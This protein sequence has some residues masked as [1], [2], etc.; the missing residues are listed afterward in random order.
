MII[1]PVPSN[2]SIKYSFAT[3][4]IKADYGDKVVFFDL[5]EI[6]EDFAYVPQEPIISVAR[7]DQELHVELLSSETESFTPDVS[8]FVVT[9][10]A[11]QPEII[12]QGE[13]CPPNV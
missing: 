9:Q 4:T 13:P 8:A 1:H 12:L 11:I 3:N 7:I 5:S 6:V 10:E 2:E